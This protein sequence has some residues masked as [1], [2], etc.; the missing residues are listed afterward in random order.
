MDLRSERLTLRP[1]STGDAEQIQSYL[2]DPTV[3]AYL[4]H[5][6]LD[7]GQVHEMLAQADAFWLSVDDERFNALFA[8]MLEER[9]IGDVHAWNMTESHELAS[10]RSAEVWI[11]YAFEPSYHGHGYATEAVRTLL[12]WLNERGARVVFA[13][14]YLE[15]SSSLR[16]LERLG[17]Q[18]HTRYTAEEDICGKDAPSCRM[19]LELE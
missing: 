17:F 6:Q 5:G 1:T 2:G 11:S 18:E 7:L 8:V 16:L 15:N 14:C 13:N 3:V 4:T 19:R 12:E 10:P 9:L